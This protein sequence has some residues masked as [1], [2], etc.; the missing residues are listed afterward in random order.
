MTFENDF[1]PHGTIRPQLN[2]GVN[3]FGGARVF[4]AREAIRGLI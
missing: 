2:L 4:A 1:T 3:E